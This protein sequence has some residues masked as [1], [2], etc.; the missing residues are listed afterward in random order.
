MYF[1]NDTHQQQFE[2]LLSVN[3]T[4]GQQNERHASLYVFSLLPNWLLE[5]FK[6]QPYV[7]YVDLILYTKQNEEKGKRLTKT[8]HQLLRLAYVLF[9]GDN[10]LSVLFEDYLGYGYEYKEV[11]VQALQLHYGLT[12]L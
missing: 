11:V 2:E 1:Y 7:S 12:S 3:Q 8:E 9:H 5:E 4:G 10:A 6:A